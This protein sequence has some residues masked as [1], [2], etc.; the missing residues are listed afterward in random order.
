MYDGFEKT[1]TS[2]YVSVRLGADVDN[3]EGVV[4]STAE[5]IYIDILSREIYEYDIAADSSHLWVRPQ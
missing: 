1:D 5:C 4:F 3:G 2:G